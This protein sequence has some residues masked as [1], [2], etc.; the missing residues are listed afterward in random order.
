MLKASQSLVLFQSCSFE[1][2]KKKTIHHSWLYIAFYTSFGGV[3]FQSK[4]ALNVGQW[5]TSIAFNGKQR[6]AT[7]SK[8]L[9]YNKRVFYFCWSFLTLWH[10][11]LILPYI[12]TSLTCFFLTKPLVL[13]DQPCFCQWWSFSPFGGRLTSPKVMLEGYLADTF[14][15]C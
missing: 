6:K 9:A 2:F 3:R 4:Q 15:K 1:K 8:K 11:L 5:D 13:L 12:V 7:I 14:T 10:H